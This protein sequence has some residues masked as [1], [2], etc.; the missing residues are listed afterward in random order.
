MLQRIK[1]SA[2]GSSASYFIAF[3]RNVPKGFY[4]LF[5]ES[6][7]V[8]RLKLNYVS[9]NNKSLTREELE[10]IRS[11]SESLRKVGI[12][13]V[14]Q[15]TPIIGMLPYFVAI[16]FPRQLLTH[17]FWSE[18]QKRSFLRE[19]FKERRQHA[20]TLKE[21]LEQEGV[22]KIGDLSGEE[23]KIFPLNLLSS[24]TKISSLDTQSE[25]HI[26][27]LAGAVGVCH[28][29]FMVSAAPTRMLRRWLIKRIDEIL[30]DDS[31]FVGTS[32]SPQL[33]TGELI[34]YCK[35]RGYDCSELRG[36]DNHAME[37]NDSLLR[38]NFNQWI[39]Q[40]EE[41]RTQNSLPSIVLYLI[42]LN[43]LQSLKIDS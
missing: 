30:L 38:N 6:K 14:L 18:D 32:S 35:R 15:S 26:R 25:K 33:N 17:H 22:I 34:E 5:V 41:L 16:K 31:H 1:T 21:L 27:A 29:Q 37:D 24:L 19:E 23:A 12:F 42:A 9:N 28:S 20:K 40:A 13:F 8:F 11:N 3:A 7:D 36:N 4:K 43:T 10:K 39:K 2:I